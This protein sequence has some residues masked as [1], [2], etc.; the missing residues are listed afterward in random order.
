MKRRAL[1]FALVL[2][3]T[4][5]AQPS[6]VC[7][8]NALRQTYAD[9]SSLQRSIYEADS[10]CTPPYQNCPPRPDAAPI[11]EGKT[12]FKL[13]ADAGSAT[14]AGLYGAWLV[15]RELAVLR[16][17][18]TPPSPETYANL[19]EKSRARLDR[20]FTQD[21]TSAKAKLPGVAAEALAYLQKSFTLDASQASSAEYVADLLASGDV[22][23]NRKFEALDWYYQS[24]GSYSTLVAKG[25]PKDV[26]RQQMTRILEK[27]AKIDRENPLTKKVEQQ[28]YK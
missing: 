22:G 8:D 12:R 14:G 10:A 9:M 5:L 24:S 21:S 2:P 3:L 26:A 11:A 27:M 18:A 15:D 16:S 1:G 7:D 17:Q 6:S 19:P 28:V 13:C 25:F 20:A 4:A 23:A